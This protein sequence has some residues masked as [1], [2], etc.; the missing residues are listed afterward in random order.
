MK[1][2]TIDRLPASLPCAL[3]IGQGGEEEALEPET[4]RDDVVK[5]KNGM[6]RRVE[7]RLQAMSS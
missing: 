5:L 4:A 7:E 3:P 6:P 1:T 2:T